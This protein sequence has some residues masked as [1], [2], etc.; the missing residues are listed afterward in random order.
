MSSERHNLVYL[1]SNANHVPSQATMK[2][3]MRIH[4]AVAY[5][6]ERLVPKG[7]AELC[8]VHLPGGT[9]VGINASVVHMNKEVFGEDVDEFRPERWLDAD[10]EQ[11]KI[12]EKS[13][14]AV[15]YP[16]FCIYT[17]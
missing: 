2:E 11:L 7:G 10:V 14:L 16:N 17:K 1:D 13:F 15:S 4:P 6:L 9:R 3:A 5:P 8:G 12:M